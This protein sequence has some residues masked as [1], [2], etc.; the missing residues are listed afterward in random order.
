MLKN[1]T[2]SAEKALIEKG[3]AWARAEGTTLNEKFRGWL[4]DYVR[5][6]TRRRTQLAR[7]LKTMERLKVRFTP[8]G[9]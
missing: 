3:R 8:P 9:F 7:H 4:G 1:I 2:F 6:E 5:E